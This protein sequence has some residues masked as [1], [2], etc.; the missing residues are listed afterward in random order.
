MSGENPSHFARDSDKASERG[1]E[2]VSRIIA[3][4]EAGDPAAASELLPLVY[5]ELRRLPRSRLAHAAPGTTIQ[6][7]A[8]VHDAY[9]RLVGEC[10][11][12]WNSRGHFFGA[13]A[14]AMRNILV[15]RARRKASLKRGGDRRRADLELEELPMAE[16]SE[17]VLALD[18]ALTELEAADSRKA[19]IVML[20]YFAGLTLRE[21]AQAIGVSLPTVER[22]WRFTRALLFARLGGD[23]A[24]GDFSK[25]K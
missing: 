7:T 3:R 23:R 4:A 2:P 15:E 10:D 24:Q 6:P 5:S 18:E 16:P 13:A 25:P 20:H 14:R 17:D 19:R 1:S 11:P 8:L 21:T 22:E 12:G 9:L